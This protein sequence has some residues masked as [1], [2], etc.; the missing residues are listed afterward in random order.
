MSGGLVQ[1]WERGGGHGLAMSFLFFVGEMELDGAVRE[2]GAEDFPGGI[3]HEITA[4][5]GGDPAEEEEVIDVVEPGVP[6]NGAAEVDAEGAVEVFGTWVGGGHG[7]LDL[8]QLFW[9]W[10]LGVDG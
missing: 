4:G 1:G 7:L 10:E 3:D 9:E 2:H 8:D 6:G 5:A